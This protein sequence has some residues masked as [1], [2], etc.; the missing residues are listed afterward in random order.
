MGF[1]KY[2]YTDLHEMNLDWIIARTKELIAKWAET[3]AAW[4]TQQEAFE[5]LKNFVN[6]YFDNL[7]VQQEIN[8]KIDDLVEDGTLSELIAPYVAEGLPAV[9][10]DQISDVV[11][12]QI[13]AVVA[14]QL[15]AEVADQLPA[16]VATETAGQAAAWLAEHVDPDTGYVIDD[17]LTVS[18]AA[19]DAK[20]TGDEVYP[21]KDF[22]IKEMKP[23]VTFSIHSL[24]ANSGKSINSSG[25][26]I[27]GQN[28]EASDLQPVK[29]GD[30]IVG[31]IY[32]A[33]S[34]KIF[35][36]VYDDQG[37]VTNT[38]TGADCGLT[39]GGV[40]EFSYTFPSGSASV[41][42]AHS[43]S[44]VGTDFKEFLAI[45]TSG[46]VN[47]LNTVTPEMFVIPFTSVSSTL[48][49]ML[50]YAYVTDSRI[51]LPTGVQYVVDGSLVLR[52]YN[53]N[54]W[55]LNEGESANL[56]NKTYRIASNNNSAKVQM[57]VETDDLPLFVGQNFYFHNDAGT[58]NT[59]VNVM[60]SGI[61]ARSYGSGVSLFK[62]LIFSNES[63]I[64][65][66]KFMYFD[67]AFESS[68]MRT[69][70]VIK[71]STFYGLATAFMTNKHKDG[72]G[73]FT[74][75]GDVGFLADSK[76][77]NCYVSGGFSRFP[78]M[79]IGTHG[80]S[81]AV[82]S[83]CFIESMKYVFQGG[84]VSGFSGIIFEG[85]DFQYVYRFASAGIRRTFFTDCYFSAFSK[86]A[87]LNNVR[88]EGI[89]D[90]LEANPTCG[91]ICTDELNGVNQE[92]VNF[93]A[94]FVSNFVN[95]CDN[96][97][98]LHGDPETEGKNFETTTI[99]ERL[100]VYTNNSE[101]LPASG[102]DV[103][104]GYDR[105]CTMES[106]NNVSRESDDA[107]SNSF[108]GQM[109]TIGTHVYYC[110]E[111]DGTVSYVKIS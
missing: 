109:V 28:T 6:D 67:V 9:V 72:N 91:I 92:S 79:F 97:I 19:A 88:W 41:R 57:I 8:N 69:V 82:I 87:L 42:L 13:S 22:I 58:Y 96:F 77:I 59:P 32:V 107:S 2:P 94:N 80:D 65:K 105:R 110:A 99:N 38:F 104:G 108:I 45:K 93:I 71:N 23:Y 75:G 31:R 55:N 100:T 47:P 102:V 50:D 43:I 21:L 18:G 95:N 1:N 111:L 30:E 84:Y 103:S 56:P 73:D 3:S 20:A 34:S 98:T 7:D 26:L 14:N 40:F 90:F 36:A 52:V 64:D 63:I 81:D 86:A 27:A 10:A 37:T 85:C 106:I 51:Y 33:T 29:Q 68:T 12:S 4:L 62:G 24:T 15:P 70:S 54:V 49:R 39:T 60:I 101:L 35:M 74:I 89:A 76:I 11:A 46:M 44:T 66:C 16:V 61:S 17:S 25:S 5:S 48:Q 53:H 78:S 83:K